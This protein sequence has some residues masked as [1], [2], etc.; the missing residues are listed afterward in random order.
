MSH[1]SDSSGRRRPALDGAGRTVA[2]GAVLIVAWGV[3]AF[4]SPYPWAYI[5][6]AIGSA[7]LGVFSWLMTRQTPLLTDQRRVII[8]LAV[9]ALT[10][11][12]QLIEFPATLVDTISPANAIVLR[13]TDLLFA[14]LSA[15]VDSGAV[16]ALPAR[17]FS[18]DPAATTRGLL[19]LVAFG[20]LLA[21]LIRH[22][23]RYGPHR[24]AEWYVWFG[25]CVAVIA[26]VQKAVLGDGAWDGMKIY[27]VWAPQEKLTTPFGPFVNKNHFAGWMLMALP[28][29]LGYLLAQAEVGL[30]YVRP[31]WRY[32]LLWLSSQQGGRFQIA[33]FSIIVMAVSL[34][35]TRSRSG[36][37]C[38]GMAMAI[39]V[40]AALRHYRSTRARLAVLASLGLLI[41]VPVLWANSNVATRFSRQD[42]SLRL[43]LGIWG[44]T[45]RIIHDF[46]VAG[47]G[48]D[49][50]ADA[51]QVYQTV[52][53]D[54]FVRQAHNDYLQVAAE[55]GW[56]VGLPAAATLFLVV[57]AIR[58]RYA[59]G[60]DDPATSWIRFGAVTG[61]AAIAL[62]SLVEFS[63]QMP[64]N[65]VTFVVLVAIALHRPVHATPQRPVLY[66][67]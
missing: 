26:I 12:L 45:R 18:I 28:T 34:M 57:I 30:R 43:R 44:D 24:F 56:L 38:F 63:L 21:G 14:S 39:A 42:E 8:G 5:P 51:M 64:G 53:R 50:L 4:G 3:L 60:D 35:M 66:K 54:Q 13:Q 25:L 17:P 41:L 36:V 48:L 62:Q 58:R 7:I 32:R 23:N 16:A 47:I 40:V 1:N 19:L 33:A 22:T 9:V 29:A 49:S 31:G 20:I 2:F 10:V 27:G 55:G 52:H 11:T 46:P 61:L 15:G 65:A 59:A 6:L 67:S 37:A